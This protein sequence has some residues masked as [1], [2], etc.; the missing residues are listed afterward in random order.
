M[1]VHQLR[2]A[3]LH[4]VADLIVCQQLLFE[5]VMVRLQ[6][7]RLNR[8]N[9]GR[10]LLSAPLPPLWGSMVGNDRLNVPAVDTVSH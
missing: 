5:A 6:V 10:P 8:G 4:F 1:G 3:V 2:H 7:R 9:R